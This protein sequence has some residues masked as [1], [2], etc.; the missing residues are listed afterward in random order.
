MQQAG[1]AGRGGAEGRSSLAICVCFNSPLDQHLWRFPDN[2]LSRGLSSPLSLPIYS[3]LVEG[4]L[5][6]AGKEFPLTNDISPSDVRHGIPESESLVDSNRADNLLL[7]LKTSFERRWRNSQQMGL[8]LERKLVFAAVPRSISFI[9]RI[10]RS[11][12]LGSVSL[13]DRLNQS[14]TISWMSR[15]RNKAGEPILSWTQPLYWIRSRT[16]ESFTTHFLGPSYPTVEGG[17]RLRA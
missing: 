5:L 9:Q 17:S 6:C 7:G 12:I 16:R 11:R 3:G 1:R 10:L 13:F 15:I 4:H 2:L 8:W 14:A